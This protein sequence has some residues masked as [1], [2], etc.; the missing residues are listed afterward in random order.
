M[1]HYYA[2]KFFQPQLISAYKDGSRVCCNIDYIIIMTKLVKK[3]FSIIVVFARS[4]SFASKD[5]NDF[6]P[7]VRLK[8]STFLWRIFK[9]K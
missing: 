1:L 9:F 3:R 2:R 7:K 8:Y 5:R 6:Y 4:N